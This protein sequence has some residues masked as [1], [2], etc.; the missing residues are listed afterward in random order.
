M[1]QE[2][3]K[4]TEIAV[5]LEHHDART[6]TGIVCLMQI[7]T[8][9]KDWIVDTLRPW[10]EELQILNQVFADPKIVKLFHGSSSDIIWLQRDLGLYVVGLF[11]TYYAC[12]A[13][14]FPAKSLKYLL[15]TFANFDAQKQYQMSDWRVRPLSAEQLEYARSD[16]HYLLHIYDHVRNLLV[17]RSRAND[18]LTNY[19]LQESKKEALQV[20][21]RFV[22]DKESGRG[23]HG[24]YPLFTQHYVNSTPAQFATFVALHEWRDKKAR[25]LDESTGF[26]LPNRLLWPIAENMPMNSRELYQCCRPVPRVVQ[27]H[28]AEVIELIRDAKHQTPPKPTVYEIIKANEEKYGVVRNRWRKPKEELQQSQLSGVAA[29]L[30]HLAK[31]GTVSTV[32]HVDEMAD[33]V[34]D[35]AHQ[36]SLYGAVSTNSSLVALDLGVAFMALKSVLPL[37]SVTPDSFIEVNGVVT[38]AVQPSPQPA[39]P[40]EPVQTPPAPIQKDEIFTLRERSRKRK[41]EESSDVEPQEAVSNGHAS[42]TNTSGPVD[43]NEKQLRRAAKVKRKAE[44]QAKKEANKQARAERID[45]GTVPFD[46]AAAPSLLTSMPGQPNNHKSNGNGVKP[47]NPFAKSLDTTTGAKRQKISKERSGKSMTFQS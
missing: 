16:T 15:W 10:R 4:A 6:Y 5:D 12:E 11:D 29:T 3:K 42:P 38:D 40:S 37:P 2:L 39:T 33:P 25:E 34:I 26:L 24:W 28:T 20:Y 43:E 18:N 46:Y 7:S 44:K 17:Q 19:V 14:Q 30:Q 1:V 9:D 31:N 41:A 35:R 45:A 22:Y 8:R 47:M 36:S 23:A 21:E 13:L 32:D 27:S